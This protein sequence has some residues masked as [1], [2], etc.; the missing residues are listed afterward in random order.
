MKLLNRS[1]DVVI[2]T[3]QGLNVY[4]QKTN[5]FQRFVSETSATDGSLNV[6]SKLSDDMVL[7][8]YDSAL[9]IFNYKTKT[10]THIDSFKGVFIN[11]ILT[12]SNNN[13]S[14]IDE[15]VIEIDTTSNLVK[16]RSFVLTDKVL[17]QLIF[18]EQNEISNKKII[19]KSVYSRFNTIINSWVFNTY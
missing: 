8:G 11:D 17:Y 2:G 16:F 1:G 6:I 10:F 19:Y 9:K 4:N 7:I 15:E 14:M 5:S 13:L 18:N 3:D 12:F